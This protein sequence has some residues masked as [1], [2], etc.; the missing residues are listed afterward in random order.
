M[1][2]SSASGARY[3]RQCSNAR[4]GGHGSPIH[5]GIHV[6]LCV[7]PVVCRKQYGAGDAGAG[8]GNDRSGP[9]MLAR[10]FVVGLKLL[11]RCGFQ[12]KV[13]RGRSGQPPSSRMRVELMCCGFERTGG[14]SVRIVPSYQQR[15]IAQWRARCFS[16]RQRRRQQIAVSGRLRAVHEDPTGRSGNSRL[17]ALLGVEIPVRT[18]SRGL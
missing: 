7:E 13:G 11:F 14:E 1:S 10:V 3:M 6:W 17:P 18:R 12:A 4:A 16:A 9:K 5:H 2:W 15:S 8:H